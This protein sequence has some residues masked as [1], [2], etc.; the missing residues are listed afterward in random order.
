[1]IDQQQPPPASLPDA[2]F[3]HIAEQADDLFYVYRFDPPRFV[4][5]SP[6]S[7]RMVGYTPEEHYAD[8][9][10]GLK[11]VHPDDLQALQA[12]RRLTPGE[13]A[14]AEVRWQ[15]RDG[16]IIWT[17]QRHSIVSDDGGVSLLVGVA[18]DITEQ[19]DRARTLSRHARFYKAL[20]EI[21]QAIVRGAD[22]HH[23]LALLCRSAVHHGGLVSAWIG[24]VDPET[25]LVRAVMGDGI[26]HEHARHVVISVDESHP[27][28]QGPTGIAIRTGRPAVAHDVLADPRL[29]PW[30]PLAERMGVRSALAIPLTRGGAAIGTL[31]LYAREPGYFDDELVALLFELAL[32]VS[33]A[34][35]GFDRERRRQRTETALR[36]SE[37]RYRQLFDLSP[38]P[39][40]VFDSGTLQFLAVNRAAV[41]RYG[42][43]EAEFLSLTIRDIRPPEDIPELEETLAKPGEVRRSGVR[44]HLT[45]G[46]EVL[47]VDV[48]SQAIRFGGRDARLVLS[49]D[50]TAQRRAERELRDSEHKFRTL[51]ET[52]TDAVFL[53]DPGGRVIDCNRQAC[54]LFGLSREQLLGVC[55]DRVVPERQPDGTLS[56]EKVG[57]LFAHALAGERVDAEFRYI[58]RGGGEFDAE[59]RMQR[60]DLGGQ[61]F[62]QIILDD[63]TEK[64][65]ADDRRREEAL[66]Y[67]TLM[68]ASFDGI[69]ILDETGR[70]VEAN[71]RFYQMLGWDPLAPPALHVSDWDAR[72]TA[73]ELRRDLAL[74]LEGAQTFETEHRRAD[75]TVFPVEVSARG[76]SLGGARVLYCAARDLSPRKAAE[77]ERAALQRA[78]LQAQKMESV[79][80]LAGGVAHDFNNLLTVIAGYASLLVEDASPDTMAHT[81][82]REISRATERASELT[83]KLLIFSRRHPDEPKVIAIDDFLQQESPLVLRLIGEHIVVSTSLDAPK[84][85]VR[86]DPSQLGQ[87]LMNLVVNARDAMPEGG[88]L[89]LSTATVPVPSRGLKLPPGVRP[90]AYARLA[91]TDSG[92]GMTPE[93]IAHL[94]EPFF[95]TKEVGKGTGLGLATAYGIVQQAGGFIDVKSTPG[96]GTTMS[97]LLP[98]VPTMASAESDDPRSIVVGGHESVMLVE[99]EPAVRELT[100]TVLQRLGYEVA[101][102]PHPEE[103]LRI[104]REGRRFDLVVTDVVM[105]GMNG[106]RLVEE[107]QRILSP[108]EVLYVSGFADTGVTG[109]DAAF[110]DQ[111]HFLAK[112][113]SP[114]SLARKVRELLDTRRR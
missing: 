88:S 71:D 61:P 78:F 26:G 33:A 37:R 13:V 2:W 68:Q 62:V 49:H 28:G 107:L 43:S 90:G 74:D 30:R 21:T 15:H 47:D 91:V 66:R 92:T 104:A 58:G 25:Q 44:R 29:A 53:A 19:K 65:R 84:T 96:V 60:V 23:L 40:W 14:R 7:T 51:F 83:R 67:K 32:D 109:T 86:V 8:P 93:V 98:V 45:K 4:Y 69:H 73:D 114:A 97:V 9:R 87:V 1:M 75:G 46:G 10:L 56:R 89:H 16:R 42:Y 17:E 95:T 94:F 106:R 31:N 85:H 63:I 100:L 20:S 102:A 50:V 57:R 3:R 76:I 38:Q 36:D 64:K 6:T 112:P 101:A 52:S 55:A 27:H 12:W 82:A 24:I 54:T 80:R 41:A 59:V 34:L 79:G 77:A 81:R 99:D 72:W 5:V 18:R 105:P 48:T 113:F 70:L 11:I 35:D 111:A 108:F 39:M 110:A 22:E 103:A